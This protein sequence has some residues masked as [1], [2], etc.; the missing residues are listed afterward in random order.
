MNRSAPWIVAM[1][2]GACASAPIAPNAPHIVTAQRIA[3]WEIHEDCADVLTGDRIDFRFDS[4]EKVEF[5]LYYRQ[6]VAVIIPLSRADVKA[7]SGVFDAQIPGHYCL[8]WKAGAAGAIVS[9]H[10]V[11]HSPRR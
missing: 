3:P 10:V 9:Y 5:D 11:V 1:L 6:G 2:L 4:T 8:A 7:D